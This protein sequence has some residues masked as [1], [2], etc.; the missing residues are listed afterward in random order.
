MEELKR[1]CSNVAIEMQ[2]AFNRVE[3]GSLSKSEINYEFFFYHNTLETVAFVLEGG[4]FEHEKLMLRV[5]KFEC[6]TL[7]EDNCKYYDFS[8]DSKFYKAISELLE[9]LDNYE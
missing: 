9:Y 8:P 2:N 5:I 7:G 4:E 6:W 3:N 1:L